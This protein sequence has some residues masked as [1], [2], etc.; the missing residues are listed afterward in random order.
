LTQQGTEPKLR[1]AAEI[2]EAPW[3]ANVMPPATYKQL[4]EDMRTVGRE[5]TDPIHVA[6]IILDGK[7]TVV[8]IDGAHRLRAAKELGWT[9]LY[10]VYHH[11]I[12]G[13]DEARIFNYRRD[14]ER[15]EVDQFKLAETFK[16]FEDGGLTQADIA[17]R[18]GLDR[19]TVSKR[20]SLLKPDQV[21]K[22]TLVKDEGVTISHL[23][24]LTTIEKPLQVKVMR[25]LRDAGWGYAGQP[26]TVKQVERTVHDVK[27][28][29]E[30]LKTW[31]KTVEEAKFKK[32]P[33]CG[34]V[35]RFQNYGNVKSLSC[36]NGHNW[37]PATG[38]DP[39]ESTKPTREDLIKAGIKREPAGLP[40][41]V[42]T[43]HH[44]QE[45]GRAMQ[46][47]LQKLWPQ[48]KEAQMASID[49]ILKNGSEVHLSY[50]DSE[51]YGGHFVYEAGKEKI[52]FSIDAVESK[53][54]TD[55]GLFSRVKSAGSQDYVHFTKKEQLKEL[56]ATTEKFL[57]DYGKVPRG[58][59]KSKK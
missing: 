27:A 26:P 59:G 42:K 33:E 6:E 43:S 29:D 50:S 37:S 16:W 52:S 25:S 11:E 32:C 4:L 17:K 8:T 58:T 5:G 14:A 28:W 19:S 47:F 30:R 2:T 35:P 31:E 9:E 13:Q 41:H 56:E 40:Q 53:N 7:P 51:D 24:P 44:P 57:Q 39:Y 46:G 48:I 22:D 34:S 1:L 23:E 49:G 36:Q 10:T 15:G 54:Y 12:T 3:N 21:V 20:V 38:K 18:F 45:Y 55:K